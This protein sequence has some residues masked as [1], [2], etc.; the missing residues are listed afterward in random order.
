MNNKRKK[1]IVLVIPK[2][3][4]EFNISEM[5]ED[6]GLACFEFPENAIR[7]LKKFLRK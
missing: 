1:P 2:T 5:L 7:V 6:K 4:S 3:E